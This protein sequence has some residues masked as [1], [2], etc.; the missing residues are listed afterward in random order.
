MTQTDTAARTSESDPGAASTSA[1]A[2]EAQTAESVTRTPESGADYA[3]S[4]VTPGRVVIEPYGTALG[5]CI[6]L[7]DERAR[8]AAPVFEHITVTPKGAT[9]GAE[10]SGMRLSG[11]LDEAVIAEIRQALLDYKVLIFR[12]QP[13]TAAEHVSFARRFGELETHPFLPG[14]TSTPELVRFEK[15]AATGGFENGWHHDVTWRECPSMGAILRAVQVPA[16]GGDTVF[17]DMA[18]AYDGLSAETRQ[19]IDDLSAVHDYMLAFG[20]A[21]PDDKKQEMREAYPQV[22]HPVVRTHPE[23]GRRLIFVNTYFTS[24]IVGL[25]PEESVALVKQLAAEADTLEYQ[26]RVAW[27]N[28][29]VVFW[30]N[31]VVQHYAVSDYHPDVRIMERAS[32]IGDRPF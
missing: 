1:P 5:P 23:T 18:A 31:R 29:M 15:D 16:T 22:T 27:E 9:L 8:L 3:G 11:D 2:E 10:V 26:Y 12:D 19:R 7:S 17:C 14:N 24:H 21:V 30:D 28:D 6:H 32:I 4:R 25:D 13:L 20:R